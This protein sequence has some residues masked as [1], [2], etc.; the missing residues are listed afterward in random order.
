MK[1]SANKIEALAMEAPREHALIFL[2]HNGPTGRKHI[3]CMAHAQ[4][5]YIAWGMA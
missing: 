2:A 5:E 3:I 4:I 1:E